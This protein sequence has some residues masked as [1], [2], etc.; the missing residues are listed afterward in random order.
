MKR[1][2]WSGIGMAIVLL[3]GVTL[4]QAATIS[5]T[6]D[7]QVTSGSVSTTSTQMRVGMSSSGNNA[8][9]AFRLP[10]LSDGYEFADCNF[11]TGIA[12]YNVAAYNVD[13]YGLGYRTTTD[14]LTSDY[15][16]G[17]LDS[18]AT[19]IQSDYVTGSLSSSV[20]GVNL[21]AAGQ[22]S[23][24]D[25][26]NAQYAASAADRALGE[27]I[28]VFLR[29]SPDSLPGGTWRY[30]LACS[31]EY[32]SSFYRPTMTYETAEVPEPASLMVLLAGGG[33]LIRRKRRRR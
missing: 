12:N 24:T 30:F 4:T 8:I 20:Q 29:M 16:S 28:Y 15:Y 11:R 5:P 27:D 9:F 22:E 26:L 1:F 6:Q 14:I 17:S 21:N 2:T 3:A 10:S 25:Y 19:L 7:A 18:S 23:L 32:S 31:T 33:L 13:F